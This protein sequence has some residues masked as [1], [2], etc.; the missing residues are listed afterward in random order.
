MSNEVINEEINET[1]EETVDETVVEPERAVVIE[2]AIEAILFAAGHPI[3]YATLARVFES[4][5]SKIRDIVFDYALKYNNSDVPRGVLLLTFSDSCQL[6]TKQHYLTEIREALGI[7]KSGTLSTS[8]L[9]TLAIVAYNQPV[10][11]SFVEQVRGVDCSGVMSSLV[12]KDL[13]EEENVVKVDEV[14]IDMVEKD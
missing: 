14:D 5:P 12:E 9:E 6:C 7:K 11:K 3:S 13:I 8:A 10:T 4:T 1:N 2:E